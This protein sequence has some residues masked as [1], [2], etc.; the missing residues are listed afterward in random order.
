MLQ[1]LLPSPHFPDLHRYLMLPR[2]P[3]LLITVKK[4]RPHQL[5]PHLNN[6]LPDDD[7]CTA[8]ST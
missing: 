8:N 4:I 2:L 6:R 1:P 7:H 5:R 3:F